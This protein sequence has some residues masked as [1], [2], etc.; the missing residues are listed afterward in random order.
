MVRMCQW[1]EVGDA[2]DS[3]RSAQT[4]L[5]DFLE[6]IREQKV[7]SRGAKKARGGRT[8]L[9]EEIRRTTLEEWFSGKYATQS[10]CEA[11]MREKF[12]GKSPARNAISK[13]LGELKRE[14]ASGKSII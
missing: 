4:A 9:Q 5:H 1:Q 13:W 12:G 6:P 8:K 2:F 3:M 14:N 7:R 10:D 11:A